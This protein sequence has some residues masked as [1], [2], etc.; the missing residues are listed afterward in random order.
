MVPKPKKA[1]RKVA[2]ARA[3]WNPRNVSMSRAERDRLSTDKAV[4]AKRRELDRKQQKNM[5][6]K[7]RHNKWAKSTEKEK[8]MAIDLAAAETGGR[9]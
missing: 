6:Y 9:P 8:S 2:K 1:P 3:K 5:R 4:L 7:T